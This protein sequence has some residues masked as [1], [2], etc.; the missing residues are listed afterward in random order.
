M[1]KLEKTVEYLRSQGRGGDT[2]LAHIN[3]MEAQM[4]K[5]MGGSGTINPNTGLPE[6]GW[7]KK[8]TGIS[9]PKVI[10]GVEDTAKDIGREIDDTVRDVVPGGW[11]TVA[12]ATGLYFAP[13]IAALGNA[14]ESAALAEGATA[15]EAATAGINAA[16]TAQAAGTDYLGSMALGGAET[17][18]IGSG[19]G[20]GLSTAPA[21]TGISAS[22]PG[23]VGSN[24]ASG[25][26]YLGGIEA[27][28]AGTAG[29][30]GVTAPSALSASDI[31]RTYNTLNNA[32]QNFATSAN[33]QFRGVG[34]GYSM[35]N[36]FFRTEEKPIMAETK[37]NQPTY[38]G[39]LAQLLRG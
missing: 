33:P 15:A 25:L 6:Y 1:D 23:V 8:V 28:P 35:P 11:L 5:A 14:A 37:T 4:L 36:P 34:Q 21:S 31:Y 39:Q 30:A 3:P 17:G 38:L 9:T 10:K 2:I 32:G 24:A 20:F 12:A 27:L 22:M 7:F 19:T 18:A 13:E 29:M 16:T 26:G